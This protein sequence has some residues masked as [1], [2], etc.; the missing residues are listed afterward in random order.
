MRPAKLG[1][2]PGKIGDFDSSGSTAVF[3]TSIDDYAEIWVDGELTRALGQS[4]G[5]VSSGWN[6]GNRLVVGCNLKPGQK[7]QVAVFGIN[8]PISN[9]PT[10]YIF[11]RNAKLS[12]YRTSSRPHRDHSE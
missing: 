4:G 10:N 11:M 9:P 8:G 7:I 12:F 2:L 1:R 6:A 3:E 5:S